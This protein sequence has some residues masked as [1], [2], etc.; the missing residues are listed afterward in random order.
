MADSKIERH[1]AQWRD[2]KIE[3]DPWDIQY[4]ALADIFLTRKSD[5]LHTFSPG[6]FLNEEVFDNT[7]QFAAF[8]YGSVLQ[9]M[10]WPDSSRTYSVNPVRR[11]KGV[12]GV[13]KYFRFVTDQM[14]TIMDNPKAGLTT[15]LA[16]HFVDM[17][18]FGTSGVGTFEGPK[19]DI[20]LPVVYESW[21]IKR[22]AIAE[23]AQGFVDVIYRERER[24]VRQ[25]LQKYTRPGDKIHKRI[26]E[27]ASA[28]KWNDKIKVLEIIEPKK[29]TLNKIGVAG[30]AFRSV[31]IDISNHKTMRESGFHEMPVSVG[32]AFKTLSEVYGRSSGMLAL[33]DAYSL[34]ALAEAVLVA[35]EKQLDPPLG[36]LDSGRLGGGVV[37]TSAG[38]LNIFND[39]GRLGG[40]NPI[41]P[42]FTVGELQSS[43][44]LM[45]QLKGKIMQAFFL[46]RLL[47]LNNQTQM[48]AFETSI[49]NR[50]RGE[51][52][53]SLFSREKTEVLTPTIE[54]TFNILYRS[55]RLGVVSGS[56]LSEEQ[57]AWNKIL[58]VDE[59][60]VPDVIVKAANDGLDIFDVEYISPAQRFQQ[61]EKL[62]G[63]FTSLEALA[64]ANAI[65]PGIVD[66]IDEDDT[67]E[68][69]VKLSGAPISMLLTK[70]ATQEKRARI[71]AQNAAAAQLE[72]AKQ[73][74]EVGRTTAQA[75]A[76]LAGGGVK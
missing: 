4:Q 57:R 1:I 22:M 17:G 20:T 13:E 38:A 8:T 47:D 36:L 73:A 29:A 52:L 44:K 67:R 62:Q 75:Q 46:D 6:E 7:G 64:S 59:V 5:F 11:L 71:Q 34:N 25:I 10:L 43:E 37:D 65:L 26:M 35:T 18:V 19:D 72:A 66:G 2:L 63:I 54:R 33:P 14:R 53:G 3:K 69:I 42:L 76:S 48:T 74:A 39:S 45:E 41:F 51:S 70:E 40:Q 9:S 15:V 21:D 68:Q 60:I 61:S 27:L 23:N 50:M 58:G 32:R 56:R 16:E 30:M 31:H 28:K 49:R 24:T 12:A 55:G